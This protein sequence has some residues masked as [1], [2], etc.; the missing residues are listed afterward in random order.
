MKFRVLLLIFCLL[1]SGCH[2]S[3]HEKKIGIIVPI[4][5]KALNE[6][7]SGFTETLQQLYPDPIKFKI[8]N[9]QGDMNLQRAIIQQMKDEQ[10]DLIVPIGTVTTQ[11]SLAAIRQQPI[12]SLAAVYS[13]QD[14]NQRKNCNIAVVRDEISTEQL[15][16]FIHRV[17]PQLSHLV[18]V[19]ST[20]DKIYPELAAAKVIGK[21]LGI[22]IK[23]MLA[24]SLNELYSLANAIPDDAQA[25]LVLKDNLIVSGIST[26]EMAAEKHHIPLITSDQG[27]VE[28]GAAFAL[29]VRERDIGMEGAKIARAI[30]FGKSACELPIVDMTHLSVFINKKIL[31]KENQTL[32]PIEVAA[33]AN[34]YRV[35]FV[36]AEDR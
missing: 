36:N 1:L 29:G 33:Q 34:K 26:L 11:M 27:S 23:T 32:L 17:Y 8:A 19:H 28:S 4:E 35:E 2:A 16:Q 6:I 14:R 22:E 20:S 25:I 5:H 10:Y 3:T 31:I 21:K 12:L 15:L 24:P 18:L 13:Q 7:I 30:L 9:A